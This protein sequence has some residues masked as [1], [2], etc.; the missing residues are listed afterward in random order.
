MA[1]QKGYEAALADYPLRRASYENIATGPAAAK[2]ALRSELMSIGSTEPAARRSL[3]TAYDVID[4]YGIESLR[5]RYFNLTENFIKRFNLRYDVRRPFT[6][7]P[8]LRASTQSYSQRSSRTVVKTSR[9][10]SAR[11]SRSLPGLAA[12][13]TS[14]RINTCLQKQVNLLEGVS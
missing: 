1:A 10:A 14:G 9:S 12:G 3:E 13:A 8:T 4:G 11:L 7:H 6:F 2:P 5:N